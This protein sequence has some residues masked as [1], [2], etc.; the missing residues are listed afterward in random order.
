MR[1]LNPITAIYL[2]ILELISIILIKVGEKVDPY[3]QPN[4]LP[5]EERIRLRRKATRFRKA[6]RNNGFW[7]CIFLR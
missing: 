5:P 6:M 1:K 3:F 2:K 4:S 7:Y